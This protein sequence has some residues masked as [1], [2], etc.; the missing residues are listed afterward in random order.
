MDQP[1]NWDHLMIPIADWSQF[2]WPAILT[3]ALFA[4]CVWS[5]VT[6]QRSD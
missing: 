5:L 3:V 4:T 2:V 1:I 6:E